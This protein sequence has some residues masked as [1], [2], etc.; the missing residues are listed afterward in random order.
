[1]T[2]RTGYRW[3][4]G[5]GG[6]APLRLAEA[7]RSHRPLS[8]VERQRIAALTIEVSVR[9]IAR[10][11]E[12]GPSTVSRENRCNTAANDVACD[13]VPAHVRARERGARSGRSRLTRGPELRAV[14]QAKPEQEWNPEQIAGHLREAYPTVRTGTCLTRRTIRRPIAA[15]RVH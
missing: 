2:K 14:V 10:R 8:M 6:V 9:K 7:V 3:R 12:R 15:R 11:L 4:A 5:A 1:M 13:A